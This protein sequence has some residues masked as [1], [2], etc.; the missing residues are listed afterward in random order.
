MPD[1]RIF[2]IMDVDMDFRSLGS[3]KSRDMFKGS[4]FYD[5]ITPIFNEPNMDAVMDSIGLGSVQVKK[6]RSYARMVDAITDP[7]D[8]MRRLEGCESTNMDHFI[9]YC[10]SVSPPYQNRI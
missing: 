1:L 9:R 8:L 10:L 6:T 3:Y 2:T 7:L 5:K 4:P